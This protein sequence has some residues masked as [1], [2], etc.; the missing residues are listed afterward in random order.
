M[1]SKLLR[2]LKKKRTEHV[3]VV[4]GWSFENKGNKTCATEQMDTGRS[5]CP[6]VVLLIKRGKTSMND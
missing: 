3:A 6:P 4:S 2:V 1:D 5:V